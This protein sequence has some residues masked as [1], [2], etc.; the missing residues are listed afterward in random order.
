MRS[1]Q[2]TLDRHRMFQHLDEVR[3]GLG[4]GHCI[5]AQ[6]MYVR[7]GEADVVISSHVVRGDSVTRERWEY[8]GP[9]CDFRPW[10]DGKV[11]P[12]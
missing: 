3:C 9:V 7:N 5:F 10:L 8:R 6:I 1:V 2:D 12:N 4:A 11:K